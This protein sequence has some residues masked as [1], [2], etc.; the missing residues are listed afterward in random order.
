MKVDRLSNVSKGLL[1]IWSTLILDKGVKRMEKKTIGV[2]L[3]IF[4]VLLLLPDP[5]YSQEEST[6]TIAVVNFEN[7]SSSSSLDYLNKTITDYINTYLVATGR[8]RIVERE[9]LSEASLRELNL[10]LTDVVGAQTSAKL[11]GIVGATFTVV[12]SFTEVGDTLLINSRLIDVQTGEAPL[13]GAVQQQGKK[14]ELLNILARLSEALK[15]VILQGTELPEEEKETLSILSIQSNPPGASIYLNGASCGLTPKDIYNLGEGTYEI[16][17]SKEG[18]ETYIK[19]INLSLGDKVLLKINLSPQ[20]G[21]LVIISSPSEAEV[22]LDE[23]YKGK[24]PLSLSS[25]SPGEHKIKLT[26]EGRATHYE[27]VV[28]K[29]EENTTVDVV[30]SANNPPRITSLTAKSR[31]IKAGET[32][33]VICTASDPDRD[34][35]SYTWSASGG[36]IQGKGEKVTYEAPG[37]AGTYSIKVKVSDN[38]GGSD[39]GELTIVVMAKSL[40]PVIQNDK[41]GYIDTSGRVV[42]EP[43]FD[44]A[45]SFS[46]GLASVEVNGKRGYIDKSGRVVIEPQFDGTGSFSEGLAEVGIDDKWGYIDKSGK[47]VIEP[48][49]DYTTSFCDGLAVVEIDDKWGYIDKSG[50]A[51]I[52]PQFDWADPFSEG[53][54]CVRIDHKNGYINASGRFV[55]APQLD[56]SR[57]FSEGLAQV[58]LGDYQGYIDKTGTVV[59]RTQFDYAWPFSEGLARVSI[60]GRVG[61]INTSGK[62]VIEPQFRN[63]GSFSDGLALVLIDHKWGYIDKSGRV[64]I[65]PQFDFAYPFSEGLARVEIDDKRGYIDETGEYFW[66]PTN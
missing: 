33:I 41:Y 24:T 47:I 18:Y 34:A 63:A 16:V 66:Y 50:R 6:P 15:K 29:V 12:G 57:P 35:L 48:Q 58:D 45:W 8:I 49:F 20:K 13:G 10:S 40:F 38:A 32:T 61:F 30:L 31:T 65:E 11:G 55:I 5:L 51:V 3:C 26:K 9:R 60:N 7:A 44:G 21:T 37:E 27:T 54:G 2:L 1:G 42:I 62:A 39:G 17:F 25:V 53:L 56:F 28:V 14:D 4:V 19:K 22:Y 36:S 52:K 59:I 46:E 43:Q 23:E 64:V